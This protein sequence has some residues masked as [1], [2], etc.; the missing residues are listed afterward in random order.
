MAVR[1]LRKPLRRCVVGVILGFISSSGVSTEAGK[2]SGR[3]SA[4]CIRWVDPSSGRHTVDARHAAPLRRKRLRKYNYVSPSMFDGVVGKGKWRWI[5]GGLSVGLDVVGAVASTESSTPRCKDGVSETCN[6]DV[7]LEILMATMDISPADREM[8][9]EAHRF[10]GGA[11]QCMG[12]PTTKQSLVRAVEVARIVASMNLDAASVAAGI[13]TELESVKEAVA[14]KTIEKKFGAEIAGLAHDVLRLNTISYLDSAG[15]EADSQA[16]NY[17]KMI[18]A[19]TNDVRAV[20]VKLA[21][22]THRVRMIVQQTPQVAKGTGDAQARISV[23][24]ETLD[25]WAPLAHRLGIFKLKTELEDASFFLLRPEVY[26]ELEKMVAKKQEKRQAYT[27][28][29]IG[30]LSEE[31]EAAG[32]NSVA[33]SG[34]AKHLYSIFSKMQ[35]KGKA[36]DQIDDLIAFRILCNDL[37]ECYQALGKIHG[38]WSPR[39]SESVSFASLRN[40]FASPKKFA[41]ASG[42]S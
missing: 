20:L 42:V 19:T 13:L 4:F 12:D 11:S 16:E 14:N 6:A 38:I 34:R 7:S 1:P 8:I 22:R 10:L 41:V 21:E 9:S 32:L 2:S 3:Q 40:L 37:A 27:N 24:K 5:H 31:M 28:T 39:P 30:I 18:L 17:R 33:I 23:A 25:I 26:K 29:V 15:H 35:A 36:L